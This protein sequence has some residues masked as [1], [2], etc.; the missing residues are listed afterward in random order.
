[1]TGSVFVD[2]PGKKALVKKLKD[3]ARGEPEAVEVGVRWWAS[4]K[5]K[6]T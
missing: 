2:V 1:M 6:K 3:A 5:E 4:F